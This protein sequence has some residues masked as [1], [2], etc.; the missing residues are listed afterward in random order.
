MLRML[1]LLLLLLL[2]ARLLI[3]L[4]LLLCCCY[5]WLLLLLLASSDCDSGFNKSEATGLGFG[6]PAVWLGPELR[7]VGVSVC[8]SRK[9]KRKQ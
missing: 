4:L 6:S 8:Q 2:H 7:R 3:P 1:L 9:S 5:C